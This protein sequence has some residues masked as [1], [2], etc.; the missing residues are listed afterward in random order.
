[1][2]H[3]ITCYHVQSSHKLTHRQEM[4]ASYVREAKDCCQCKRSEGLRPVSEA[5]DCC[6][7]HRFLPIPSHPLTSIDMSRY[8]SV[9]RAEGVWTGYEI[10][11]PLL[12]AFLTRDRTHLGR[13]AFPDLVCSCPAGVHFP[14]F[15]PNRHAT[16]NNLRA[17]YE[18][19]Q[20]C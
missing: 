7:W 1:M 4:R 14:L 16:G 15:F 9:M 6:R 20:T 8:L 18:S 2:W 10:F 13:A 17:A 11:H 5:K 12:Q 3:A 19:P